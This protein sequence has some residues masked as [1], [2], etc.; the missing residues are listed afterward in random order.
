MSQASRIQSMLHPVSQAAEQIA[1]LWWFMLAVL[2]AVTLLVFALLLLGL[3]RRGNPP[4]G[5]TAFVVAGG[6]VVP[7]LI[8]VILLVVA[9]RTTVALKAAPGEFTIQVIGHQWWWEVRYP[10][11][12][13]VT[14]NELHLPVGRDVRLEVWSADVIH[15]FWVPRL[16]GKIDL[17]PEVVNAIT[18]R[19]DQAGEYRGQCA[20][21]CGKQHAKMAFMVV[22]MPPDDFDRW[23]DARR[24]P[25]APPTEA[26][27]LRG[28][29]A[30]FQAQCHACHAIRGTAAVATLGPDLTHLGSRLT[31]GA[32]EI[33]NSLGNLQGWIANPQAI[34]PGNLMPRNYLAPEDLH[35]IA[36]YLESLK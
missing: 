23:V 12:E 22:A 15:S 19:A 26:A 36:A 16:H 8:L 35:A 31:L 7:A 3:L 5:S 1:G 13:I 9:L 18:L 32:G 24:S 6:I 29:D 21:F 14:A 30:F 11:W 4:G 27:L 34:K 20:E 28:H 2:S 10:E 17:L 25:P 33:P